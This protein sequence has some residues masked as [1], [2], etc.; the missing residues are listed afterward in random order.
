MGDIQPATSSHQ[1]FAS[2]RRL[3]FVDMHRH[4][5]VRQ[6]FGSHETC[7]TCSDDS[8]CEQ[9]KFLKSFMIGKRINR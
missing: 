6:G 2:H 7:R 1:E 5:L 3:G 9:K 8:D 4:T